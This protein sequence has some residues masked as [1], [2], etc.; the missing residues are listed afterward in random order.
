MADLIKLE[1]IAGPVPL[2]ELPGY[3]AVSTNVGINGE[4]IRLFLAADM[5][6]QVFAREQMTAGHSF[7]KTHTENRY[8]ANLVIETGTSRCEHRLTDLNATTPLVQTFAD[9]AVLV[10]A[11]RCKHFNDGTCELNARVFSSS[12]SVDF[13]L[14]DGIEHIQ[15]DGLGRIW[16]GYFDEGVFGNFGWG[17]I[18]GPEPIG[19]P[20]LVCFDRTGANI[21]E[22]D[23]PSGLDQIADCYAMNV[24]PDYVWACY[25]TDFPIVRIDARGR[26]DA[27]Q[28]NLRGPREL[29]IAG[30][31]LL[32]FGGYGESRNSCV[33][34]KLIQ[35]RHA[36]IVA[37]VKLLLPD[38]VDLSKA[39]VIGRGEALHVFADDTL[40]KFVVPSA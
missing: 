9:G 16:V 21:W 24:T 10:V 1:P 18:D 27:W 25:Y 38:S 4:V 6:D 2:A 11:P 35:G 30:D 40:F 5:A 22:F 14:G 17:P 23:A 7:P 37:N 12:R 26:V 19:S 39:K 15:I 3:H 13:C 28:T 8:T 33:L 32:A 34:L 31:S 29:A 20:G 36:E